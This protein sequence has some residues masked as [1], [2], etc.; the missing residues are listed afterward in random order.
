MR[1]FELVIALEIDRGQQTL[2]AVVDIKFLSSI[3]FMYTCYGGFSIFPK[4]PFVV[5]ELNRESSWPNSSHYPHFV[6]RA[7]FVFSIAHAPP[8]EATPSS[9]AL[10]S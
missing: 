3:S 2:F 1:E 6:S 10:S 9:T 7:L 4:E 8:R 5:P